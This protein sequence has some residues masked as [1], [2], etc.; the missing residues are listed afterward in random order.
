MTAD[1]ELIFTTAG[2]RCPLFDRESRM[3]SPPEVARRDRQ[4]AR[5]I[6]ADPGDAR[7]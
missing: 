7:D 5:R 3:A 6:V 1:S 2:R 4:H